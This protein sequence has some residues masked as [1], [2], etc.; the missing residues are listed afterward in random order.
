VAF[1][2]FLCAGDPDLETTAAALRKLDEVGADIIE[3]GVPYSDPLA[4]GPTIQARAAARRRRRFSCLQPR[5]LQTSASVLSPP[6]APAPLD[7]GRPQVPIS[8]PAAAR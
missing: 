3:L 1:I 4:D 2:P 5:A 7:G 8:H 6:G